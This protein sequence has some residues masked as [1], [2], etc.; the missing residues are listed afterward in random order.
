MRFLLVSAFAI[1]V[2][3]DALGFANAATDEEL[4]KKVRGSASSATTK[5]GQNA[6]VDAFF[7][8]YAQESASASVSDKASKDLLDEIKLLAST[9]NLKNFLSLTRRALHRHPELMYQES[10]TSETIQTVLDDL[11][12]PYTTGWSKNTHEDVYPGKGGYGI[13][14]HIGRASGK[15]PGYGSGEDKDGPCVIL[16]ADM[17]AL[18][19]EEATKN[20]ESFKSRKSGKMH[21]C[22]HDGH[23]TMLLGAAALLKTVEESIQGTVRLV[24]QPAEEGGAGAKRMIEEGLMEMEPKPQHAFGLHVW[25]TIPSGVIASR[26]G[27]ILAAADTFEILMAGKGG[28]AAMPHLT[29]DPIVASSSLVMN[30]QTIVARNLSPLEE[31]VVSV[32]QFSGGDAFNVIPAA[33]T[34]RGTIRALSVDT[35]NSLRE[36][37]EKMLEATCLLHGTNSTIKFSPDYYLPTINDPELFEFSKDVAG[38]VSKEGYMRDIV[39][40]MGGE[41]FSFIA[42]A[43]PST[44]FMIGQGTGGDEKLHIPRTDYGLHH[45][46]FNLD[47]DVMPVGVE[48]HVNIALRTLAELGRGDGPSWSKKKV[49]GESTQDAATAAL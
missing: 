30:L 35:L 23:T 6:I 22:G 5:K 28:H 7:Q 29:I 32:T 45:P 9:E 36:R 11:D 24:F 8:S 15:V 49:V 38:M 47:E 14:A 27:P 10:F 4:S 39:P 25:P 13:V 18:P 17:D 33:V 1:A 44:F 3:A 31:G 48:L 12:I 19:I 37:V 42:D 40:T 2:L 26:P 43:I 34:I 41:D 20:V 16:R 46:S 21:A